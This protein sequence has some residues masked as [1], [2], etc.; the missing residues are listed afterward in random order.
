MQ[1]P[2]SVFVKVNQTPVVNLVSLPPIVCAGKPITLMANG[3]NTYAWS[4]GNFGSV[5]TVTPSST[6]NNFA[7]IGTATNNCSGNAAVTVSVLPLPNIAASP[8]RLEICQNEGVSLSGTGGQTYT[9]LSSVSANVYQ[10]QQI[11]VFPMAP[12]TYTA[13]G[14]DANGCENTAILSV[15]VLECTGI[16]EMN[17][18]LHSVR[19]YPNPT[20]GFFTIESPEADIESI[21]ITDISGR[22]VL[23][24]AS[25]ELSPVI[26][27]GNAANGLYYVKVKTGAGTA[28]YR[29]I[30]N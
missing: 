6:N 23:H 4:N 1:Q 15:S 12:A 24:S 18:A 7:V 3:A 14:A 25:S 22:I 9:W 2:A 11:T 29:L 16:T 8:S 5:I 26:D 17:P 19:V 10:G 27:L 21:E 28:V 20:T 30:R 13:I